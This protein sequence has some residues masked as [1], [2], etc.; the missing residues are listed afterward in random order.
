MA[1]NIATKT[2]NIGTPSATTQTFAHVTNSGSNLEMSLTI[3]MSNAVTVTGVTYNGVEM[4]LVDTNTTTTTA[5]LIYLFKLTNPGVGT[6]NVVITF[7][8]GQYNPVSSFAITA[9]GGGGI[10]N[11]LFKDTAASPVSGN[12]TVSTNSMILGLLV[13]GNNVSHVITLDGSSRALE[14]THNINNYTSG[15]LSATGLTSGSKTV[16]ISAGANLGGYFY[17]I[18]EFS[19]VSTS[20]GN[21]MMMF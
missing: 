1:L 11:T 6:N 16:S 3:A 2:A 8:S 10:G 19:S 4:T 18:K 5:A 17:E 14:Y 21:M 15:A 12:L 9:S 7:S 13:A 20:K